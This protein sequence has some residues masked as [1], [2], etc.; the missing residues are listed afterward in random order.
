MLRMGEAPAPL[1]LIVMVVDRESRGTGAGLNDVMAS[2]S[3]V[4][5]PDK[6]EDYSTI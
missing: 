3:P 4:K 6:S 2:A 5:S 1:F